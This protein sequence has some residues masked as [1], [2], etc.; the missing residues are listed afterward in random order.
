MFLHLENRGP[1]EKK[2][3]LNLQPAPPTP[4]NTVKSGDPNIF[5][6]TQIFFQPS[7]VQRQKTAQF[8]DAKAAML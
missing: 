6:L 2:V 1:N 7:A 3:I 5:E 4:Q 8:N